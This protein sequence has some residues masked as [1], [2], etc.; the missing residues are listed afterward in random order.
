MRMRMPVSLALLALVTLAV[1]P[2]LVQQRVS[3]LRQI[4]GFPGIRGR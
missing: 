2:L 1:A 3:R 4:L